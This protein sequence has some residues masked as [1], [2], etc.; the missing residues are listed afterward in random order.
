MLTD[1]RLP[2][3]IGIPGFASVSRMLGDRLGGPANA[4]FRASIPLAWREA[5]A[6]QLVVHARS[7]VKDLPSDLGYR[8]LTHAEGL[9]GQALAGVFAV[10]DRFADQTDQECFNT[11]G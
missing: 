11:C 4:A 9:V 6:P 1:E 8:L 3:G 2:D 10:A 5:L 7:L